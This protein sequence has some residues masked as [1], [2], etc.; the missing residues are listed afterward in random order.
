MLIKELWSCFVSNLVRCNGNQVCY[1]LSHPSVHKWLYFLPIIRVQRGYY[2]YQI[3]VDSILAEI[4]VFQ[5]AWFDF[6]FQNSSVSNMQ[7]W[8]WWWWWWKTTEK[9]PDFHIHK[10]IFQWFWLVPVVGTDMD[11]VPSLHPPIVAYATPEPGNKDSKTNLG[12]SA[13]QPPP[14]P[15][16]RGSGT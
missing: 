15:Y 7:T 16:H 5:N 11:P 6:A 3:S 14:P 12:A 13:S 9:N 1:L 10:C 4:L 2:L 8:Q